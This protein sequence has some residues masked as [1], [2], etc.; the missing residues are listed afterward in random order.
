[1]AGA[2]TGGEIG[3]NFGPWGAAI[4]FAIGGLVS[5][6]QDLFG[7]GGPSLPAWQVR[8]LTYVG[9]SVEAW[10]RIEGM[11]QGRTLMQEPSAGLRLR[12][13]DFWSFEINVGRIVGGSLDV[14]RAR[15]ASWYVAP[16]IEVGKSP[17]VTSG[18][19][20]GGVCQLVEKQRH[21][22]SAVG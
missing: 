7:G 21:R 4:G 13:P 2:A 19:F 14:S 11:P 9:G 17:T 8:E 10:R 5:L 12:Y 22:R 1:M 15:Y 16:G 18:S 20:T 3:S 6:F